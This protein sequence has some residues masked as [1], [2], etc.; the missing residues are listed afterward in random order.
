MKKAFHYDPTE[1]EPESKGVAPQP[2][3]YDDINSR[4]GNLVMKAVSKIEAGESEKES[5]MFSAGEFYTGKSY[6]REG[7]LEDLRAKRMQDI[8]KLSGPPRP[9]FGLPAVRLV[10]VSEVSSSSRGTP[11][12][13]PVDPISAHYA[14]TRALPKIFEITAEG[15]EVPLR[16]DGD[17][18]REDEERD[19]YRSSDGG[20]D[21]PGRRPWKPPGSPGGGSDGGGDRGPRRRPPGSPGSSDGGGGGRGPRTPPPEDKLD[22]VLAAMLTMGETLVN[23]EKKRVEMETTS[24]KRRDEGLFK[25]DTQLPEIHGMDA[26]EKRRLKVSRSSRGLSMNPISKRDQF[27]FDSYGKRFDRLRR[28][29]SRPLCIGSLV[30]GS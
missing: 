15:K 30:W 11:L 12:E 3:Y 5:N 22:R 25:I 7:V 19:P 27:G 9:M 6:F 14:R 1:F 13:V 26:Q 18:G 17:R 16:S 21:R 8:D 24:Q 4:T 29:G 28:P 20:D 2:T 10:R 23:L